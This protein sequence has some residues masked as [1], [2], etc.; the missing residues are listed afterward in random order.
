MRVPGPTRFVAVPDTLTLAT[1]A[2]A[3]PVPLCIDVGGHA[4]M[5]NRQL[6]AWRE[7]FAHALAACNQ[8]KQAIALL[9]ADDGMAK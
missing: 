5:C 9:P 8:D 2:P 7:A 1:A 3:D 4:V 6:D